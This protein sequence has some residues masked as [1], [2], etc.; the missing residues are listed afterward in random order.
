MTAVLFAAADR[1]A[2]WSST[3]CRGI[4]ISIQLLLE[5]VSAG[6]QGGTIMG[7]TLSYLL[8]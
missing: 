6:F 3:L 4:V 1:S 5:I 2:V 8:L 7:R